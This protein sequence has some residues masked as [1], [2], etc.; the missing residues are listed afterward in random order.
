[1]KYRYVSFSAHS[2]YAQTSEFI[3]VCDPRCVSCAWLDEGLCAWLDGEVGKGLDKEVGMGLDK[4]GMG[5]G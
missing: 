1:M 2:D 4:V 3:D 5:A